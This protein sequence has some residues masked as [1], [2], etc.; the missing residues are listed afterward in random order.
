M[1][2]SRFLAL[3]DQRPENW[4]TPVLTDE[5][6]RFLNCHSG[7]IYVDGTLGMGGHARGILEKT[8]P[9][10]ILIG[11]DRDEDSLELARVR[12][13]PFGDRVIFVHENFRNLLNVLK[14]L[15]ISE[16]DGLL[17]DLGLSS[18]Q[19]EKS[20]RGFSFRHEEP[21]DMRMDTRAQLSAW[22][23][24][25]RYSERQLEKIIGDYGEESWARKIAGTITRERA[26]HT[27]DTAKELARII[28]SAIPRKFQSSRI[29]PATRTFQ[30]IRIVVNQELDS[31]SEAISDAAGT[32]KPFGR[33]CVISFHSLEDRIVKNKFL[34]MEKTGPGGE[35]PMLRRLTRKPVIP[36]QEESEANPRARSA[37][38][39]AA[40]RLG[41]GDVRDSAK[42]NRKTRAE[43]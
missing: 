37:K 13:A 39:R 1:A 19:L 41:S 31:V 32:L 5:V 35:P 3:S 9:D 27:I 23:I 34:E 38:L 40:E 26:K 20:G 28:S 29:H 36:S 33:I 42:T 7:G 2:K 10:G 24:V 22:E 21:L 15:Q 43:S 16:I 11:I 4:H 25:N 30:A 17:L 6:L 12:L 14:K 8:S 18:Y